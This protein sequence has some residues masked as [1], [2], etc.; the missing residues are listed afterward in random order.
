MTAFVA[1]AASEKLHGQ[2]IALVGAVLVV[3][4]VLELVRR[5]KIGERFSLLW[6]LIAL[7]MLLGATILFPLLFRLAP[8]FGI[9]DP[10]SAVFLLAFGGL[11]LLSLYFTVI[12]TKLSQQNRILAQRV[13]LLESAVTADE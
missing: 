11:V 13:A 1:A 5:R 4:L 6:L 10:V 8:Y 7:A 2:R 9:V 12:L 3:L